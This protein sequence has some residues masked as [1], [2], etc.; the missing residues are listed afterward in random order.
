M[1]NWTYGK[2]NDGMKL[3]NGVVYL[4]Q[5][6][7]GR[8]GLVGLSIVEPYDGD[9]FNYSGEWYGKE[10]DVLRAVEL[11]DVKAVL[12]KMGKWTDF[13]GGKDE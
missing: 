7:P 2:K 5:W 8:E 11:D 3:K 6:R 13:E 9:L 10:S 1:Q 4:V 12:D